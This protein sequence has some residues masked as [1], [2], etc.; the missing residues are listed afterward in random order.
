MALFQQ[1]KF[2]WSRDSLQIL[3]I[4][5]YSIRLN[6]LNRTNPLGLQTKEKNENQ[7]YKI[8]FKNVLN[9]TLF[10]WNKMLSGVTQFKSF[11]ILISSYDENNRNQN[12]K[13]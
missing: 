12:S 7:I 3:K 1:N 6:Y 13:M 9:A 2:V 11:L 4:K 10:Q 8:T 5:C